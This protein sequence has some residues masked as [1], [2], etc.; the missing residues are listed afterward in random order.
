MKKY[1]III[2]AILTVYACKAQMTTVSTYDANHFGNNGTYY[3]DTYNDYN[4][5]E[6]TWLY[7]NG[8]TSF[9]LVLQKKEMVHF[10]EP[11]FNMDYYVDMIAGEYQYIENGVELVNTLSNLSNT[12][13]IYNIECGAISKYGDDYC[14]GCDA[15]NQIRIQGGLTEPGCGGAPVSNFHLRYYTDN[16]IEKLQATFNLASGV[17]NFDENGQ[18][19]DNCET[20]QIPFGEYVFVKQ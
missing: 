9:K 7:T 11:D 4:R 2:L 3:K 18:P 5:F 1:I 17:T 16:G 20:Y 14:V 10:L 15:P 8:N 13:N 12:D 6:G 19:I